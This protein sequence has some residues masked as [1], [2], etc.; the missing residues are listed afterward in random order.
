[1]GWGPSPSSLICDP[2]QGLRTPCF[3]HPYW[4]GSREGW[5]RGGEGSK[6][7]SRRISS[8]QY[9]PFESLL[10]QYTLTKIESHFISIQQQK[11]SFLD[12][13][14]ANV[15][16]RLLF[17]ITVAKREG[18]MRPGGGG[19]GGSET[20]RAPRAERWGQE[21][22]ELGGGLGRGAK[23][24]RREAGLLQTSSIPSPTLTHHPSVHSS[25]DVHVQGRASPLTH[26]CPWMQGF[27]SS[28]TQGAQGRLGLSHLTGVPLP[29]SPCTLWPALH[30][31]C[32]LR[33]GEILHCIS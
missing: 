28:G 32:Q 23:E 33:E 12:C 9:R 16:Q 14:T 15:F 2:A 25:G 3:G 19:T 7:N 5:T 13:Y 6:N 17:T 18:G 24:E 22:K 29:G 30:G 21:R 26:T 20:M 27:P 8:V 1:M 10:L 4:G 11:N 31:W